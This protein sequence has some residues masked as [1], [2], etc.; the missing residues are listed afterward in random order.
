M[1][2]YSSHSMPLKE[3]KTFHHIEIVNKIYGNLLSP[4]FSCH[5]SSANEIDI[6]QNSL[7]LSAINFIE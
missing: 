6:N 1:D 5:Y 4:C 7:S 3:T 2:H